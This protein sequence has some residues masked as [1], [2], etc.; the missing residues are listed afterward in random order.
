MTTRTVFLVLPL[1]TLLGCGR[2]P[3]RS[4]NE[5]VERP[6]RMEVVRPR[7]VS[8]ARKLEMAATVEAL[9]RIELCARVPGV[10]DYLPDEMDIGRRVAKDEV[11]LRLAVPELEA[12]KKHKEALLEQARKQKVQAE[13][14]RTVAER[15]VEEAQRQEKRYAADYTFQGLKHERMRELVRRGAQE[16][17]MEQEARQQMDAA[18][19]ALQAA[20]AQIAT[21]RAKVRAAAADLE[22]AENRIQVAEAEVEKL[23]T[24]IAFATVRAP[25]DGVITR[26][27]VDPGA[28]IKDPPRRCSRSCSWT[29]SACSSTCRS[30]TCRWSTPPSR[31]P[32]R[33]A[34]AT[35]RRC[36]SRPWWAWFPTASSRA[37]S[38]G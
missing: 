22:V 32:T 23:R 35:L 16:L 6:P 21:R 10:V 8:L 36:A 26:R 19:A 5:R 9:K 25:F 29:A 1:L 14:A 7:R 4:T 31:T 3:S 11:L 34:G 13:E 12:D 28:T 38:P 20:R 2:G 17:Q 37:T 18:D 24:A 27:W 33:T 30:V 15:E